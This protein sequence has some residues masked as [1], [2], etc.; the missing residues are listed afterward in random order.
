MRKKISI[1]QFKVIKDKII[2]MSEN[3]F[4]LDEIE[5]IEYDRL[6]KKF[7]SFDLSDIPFE[8]YNG[9]LIYATNNRGLD[10]SKTHANIDFEIGTFGSDWNYKGCNVRNIG[11]LG[12]DNINAKYFDKKTIKNNQ[13]IFLSNRFSRIFKNKFY[14]GNITLND[15]IYLNEIQILELDEKFTVHMHMKYFNESKIVKVLGIKKVIKLYNYSKDDYELIRDI[16]NLTIVKEGDGL[17]K[18]YN[19]LCNTNVSNM[20]NIC[21]VEAK[22]IVITNYRNLIDIKN[23]PKELVEVLKDELLIDKEMSDDLRRKIYDRELILSDIINNIDI[24]ENVRLEYFVSSQQFRAL[25]T[26]LG[27]NNFIKLLKEHT[28]FF[29]KI[30]NNNSIGQF[31][32]YFTSTGDVERDF[33]IAAR[34]YY[35]ELYSIDEGMYQYDAEGNIIYEFH[36]FMKSFNLKIV[37][38]YDNIEKFNSYDYRTILLDKNQK[39][40]IEIF[41]LD[42]I[43]RFDRET[44]F[45]SYKGLCDCEEYNFGMDNIEEIGRYI[46]NTRYENVNFDDYD[47]FLNEM[48]N[49]LS[50]MRR[51]NYFED[52]ENF[53]YDVIEGSFRKKYSDIFMDKEAPIELRRAFYDGKLIPGIICSEYI[54]FLVNRKLTDIL[55]GKFKSIFVSQNGDYTRRMNFIDYYTEKFGNLELLKLFST[56]G[57]LCYD[58][59]E[60]EFL[61]D[62]DKEEFDRGFRKELYKIILSKRTLSYKYLLDSNYD[63]FRNEYPDIFITLDE[64][65]IANENDRKDIYDKFYK[66]KIDF[67]DIKKYPSLIEVLKNKNL[68]LA[69]GSV[70][71]EKSYSNCVGMY[72]MIF[73]NC[74][75]ELFLRLSSKYGRYI[76]CAVEVAISYSNSDMSYEDICSIV[77]KNIASEC[78]NGKF[79][80]FPEDAPEFLK[81]DYPELFLSEDA[82]IELMDVFYKRNDAII[83]F[84]LLKDNKE[85]LPY[86]NGKSIRTPFFKNNIHDN[87][88]KKYFDLFGDESAL[89]LGIQKPSVVEKMMSD[90]KVELMKQWYDKTGGKFVPDSVVMEVFPIKEA[91]KFLTSTTWWSKLMK[92]ESFSNYEEGRDV[93]LKLAYAFGVFDNDVI[94]VRKLCELLTGIPRHLSSADYDY[95]L[96]IE[97]N[98]SDKYKGGLYFDNYEKLCGSLLIAG[99]DLSDDGTV[100]RRIYRKNEDG[101]VNLI[102]N[103]ERYK[104]PMKYLRMILEDSCIVLGRDE[105]HELFGG[106]E[107]TYDK[108]FR[109]FLLDNLIS[110]RENYDYEETITRIQRNFTKI[111]TLNSNRKLT[112]ELAISFI[113]ENKYEN[114]NLGNDKV[115]EVSAIAGYSQEQFDTLQRIYNYGKQRVFSSIPRIEKTVDGYYYE[116]LRLDDPL[117][118]AIGTLTN[119]CQELGN[120]A[121]V[122]MQHSMTSNDGRI[123][124]IRDNDGNIVAQSWVWRN[125]DVICFDNIEIPKKAFA[126]ADEENS[127]RSEFVNRICSLYKDAAKELMEKDEKTY[128]ILL[129][130]EKIT[131]E[132]Y[133]GLKLR[134]VTVG[135]GYNDIAD[136]IRDNYKMV[137]DDVVRPVFYKEPVRLLR[138]LYTKDS[139]TQYILEGKDRIN[140]YN[141]NNIHIYSDCYIEYTDDNFDGRMLIMLNNMEI[142]T[143]DRD[144]YLN[145]SGINFGDNKMVSKIANNI[146]LNPINTRIIM[147]PNFAIIYEVNDTYI[148]IGDLYFNTSIYD[149]EEEIDISATV[150]MQIRCALIQITNNK[151]IDISLLDE[152]Q[153]DMYQ[154]VINYDGNINN[155]KGFCLVRRR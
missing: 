123:F 148:K 154:K 79:S 144:Y 133:D 112:L 103:P 61:I 31:R 151:D 134:E 113:E 93:L 52:D 138:S 91:D 140:N 49:I 68:N 60:A 119:C 55:N 87:D 23:Y 147:N 85:W 67:E 13:D 24:F 82:P 64:I 106:F 9:M 105:A 35:M 117:A 46:A 59:T 16:L 20:K 28:E 114:V 89:K 153:K 127:G 18:F 25:I 146:E 125:K 12:K 22:E 4:E 26:D 122:C 2:A 88:L 155:E 150:I 84:E 73:D 40:V 136:A 36:D 104:T 17:I 78:L 107:L 132:E 131:K 94:G 56:Y 14:E 69:F 135:I 42:N 34:K 97:D 11:K 21:L 75:N 109:E 141:G 50:E 102:I 129:D 27:S 83:S 10:F 47:V 81:K 8:C 45:F 99:F 57:K 5:N 137:Y 29:E 124:V 100:F 116:M 110:I 72:K 152:K 130:E 86:L 1:E 126:R 101:S 41:G 30:W 120:V 90:S 39:K 143:K 15:M 76:G 128:K 63:L 80:Y 3:Y 77:E 92:I 142:A 121:E 7:L 6:I 54:P 95:L 108:D 66:R 48:A 37:D 74:N 96:D 33:I 44:G 145:T 32:Y 51:Q 53:G 38:S 43:L 71:K 98:I 111:K 58:L 115:A 70:I 118:M 19:K 139:R 65:P 149:D 62:V